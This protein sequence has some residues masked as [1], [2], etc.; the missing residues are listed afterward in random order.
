MAEP[1]RKRKTYSR[2][3]TGRRL[4]TEYEI[5]SSDLHYHYPANFELGPD[6]PVIAWYYE[7]REGS[8]LQ[9]TNWEAFGDPR[10]TT[11]RAYNELQ[12]AREDVIDC[13]LREIDDTGYDD[14]LS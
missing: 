1:R 5:V 9:A 11:Y 7:H 4:P 13:L 8:P 3:E 14:R 10:R 2:L 12:D 6:N